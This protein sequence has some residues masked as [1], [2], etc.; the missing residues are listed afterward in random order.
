M[1]AESSSSNNNNHPSSDKL[2]S[3]SP[4]ISGLRT[5]HLPNLELRDAAAR[6]ALGRS[7]GNSEAH[8]HRNYNDG[9]RMRSKSVGDER[10][11]AYADHDDGMNGQLYYSREDEI[12]KRRIP[13]NLSLCFSDDEMTSLLS[14]NGNADINYYSQ[15]NN[16]NY[17]AIPRQQQQQYHEIEKMEQRQ[18]HNV[19]VNDND[20]ATMRQSQSCTIK[21]G[22][23]TP[24]QSPQKS[25]KQSTIY[26]INNEPKQQY[27][28]SPSL[29]ILYGLINTSIVLPVLMSFGSIIYHDDFFKPYLSTL[30]KLTV[31]SGAVHQITFTSTSSLPFAVGQVQDA[32]LIFLSA[33][34]TDLVRR[35]RWMDL[36]D[37][38]V[39]ATLLPGSVVG[40]YLA[41]I[42]FFCGQAGL[43]LMA[44]ENV[45]GLNDWYKFM[46]RDA[47]IRTLPGIIGGVFIYISVRTIK[48]MAVLPSCIVLIMLLFYSVLWITGT[49][50]KEATDNGWINES[51]ES[52]NWKHT[53]DYLRIDKVVWSVLPSQIGTLLA[54]ISVVALSSSLD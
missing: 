38:E 6:T 13:S 34:S 50:V 47:I 31:L 43:A 29:S 12:M 36:K 18:E 17:E 11:T 45:T 24:N 8:P 23:T 52:Q 15:Y 54:M 32:G 49:T 28:S 33:I 48:H 2:F 53:W 3:S 51:T 7:V 9:G 16:N 10:R 25:S 14:K 40:G 1:T 37:E 46:N 5:L 30:L 44:R 41:Y 42:G 20:I 4:M 26:T 19:D 22:E 39:L 21:L 35:T 27:S